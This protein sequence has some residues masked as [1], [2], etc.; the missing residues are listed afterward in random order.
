MRIEECS[1]GGAAIVQRCSPRAQR[2]LTSL[3][4]AVL[5]DEPTSGSFRRGVYSAVTW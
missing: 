4:R 1:G 5:R 2:A 3:I